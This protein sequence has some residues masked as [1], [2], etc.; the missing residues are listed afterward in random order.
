VNGAEVERTATGF[1]VRVPKSETPAV[2]GRLLAAL[3]VV[4]LTI[5]EPPVEQ[6]IERVF[7]A[8]TSEADRDD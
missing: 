2:A 4:D 8:P 1:A 3:P 6:V 7:A 5:T